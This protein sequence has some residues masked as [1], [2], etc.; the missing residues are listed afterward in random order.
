MNK[1]QAIVT[2]Y[3]GPSNVRGSRIKATCAAKSITRG[4]DSALNV[5]ENHEAVAL[6]LQNLLGWTGKDYG[7][8]QGGCMKNGDYCWVLVLAEVSR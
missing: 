4:Y 3:I 1:R 8:L 7:T 6:E 5:D 2:R